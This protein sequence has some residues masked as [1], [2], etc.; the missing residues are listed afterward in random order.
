MPN[1]HIRNVPDSLH[2]RL[3]RRAREAN[4]SMNAV[5]LAAV[6]RE[7]ARGEWEEHLAQRP[8]TELGVAA[9]TLLYEERLALHW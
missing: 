3:R 7:L 6:E 1:L 2:E 9:A 4:C 8:K 5:V